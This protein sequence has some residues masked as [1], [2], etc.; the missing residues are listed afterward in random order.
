MG[1]SKARRFLLRGESYCRFGLPDYVEFDGVLQDVDKYLTTHALSSASKKAHE[2]SRVNHTILDNK[3]GRYAWRPMELIHPTLYVDLVRLITEKRNWRKL[4]RRFEA[5]N[6]E[7]RIANMSIPIEGEKRDGKRPR[8]DRAAMIRQ[9]WEEIEQRSIRLS[10]DYEYVCHTDI[11]DCYGSLYTHSVAWAMHG[12]RKAKRR[13]TD[14]GLL[15]N[16]IDR[17]LQDMNEGQTNGVPQGSVLIDLIVELVLCYADRK[18]GQK[19]KLAGIT[20]YRVLRYRD[21]Y[22]IFINSPPEGELLVKIVSE[23]MSSM[24][25]K[26]NPGKTVSSNDVLTSVVKDDKIR[27]NGSVQRRRGLQQHLMLIRE[28]S[29][30]HPHSGSLVKALT[31]F[32]RRLAG[33][34]KIGSP[35]ELLSLVV[36]IALRNPR[37]YAVCA[38]IISKLLSRL[39]A[40]ERKGFLAALKR[41]FDKIPH[42][43]HLQIWLQ[44]L[45]YPSNPKEEYEK[46]MCALVAGEHADIWNSE[47]ITSKALKNVLDPSRIVNGAKLGKLAPI[48]SPDEVDVFEPTS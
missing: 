3:D 13:R 24:G 31:S 6:R 20:D 38:S 47:W 34:K 11:A 9:W 42:T 48:I 32:D 43:G 37:T 26:L 19:A 23:V 46:P 14:K 28:L 17:R 4:R 15:G 7:R 18:I 22:R 2:H 30:S 5:L 29:K 25:L 12:K 10:L 40:R 16:R 44:R 27:W 35:R 41:R 36:D 21:D 39:K 45:T 8:R 1:P 33:R